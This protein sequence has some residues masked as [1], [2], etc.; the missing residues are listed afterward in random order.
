MILS[1]G[2]KIHLIVR[3]QFENDLRRHFVGEVKAAT[4]I[5]ARIESY[6]FVFDP[7]KNE[8]AKRPEMRTKIVSLV[9]NGNV[10]TIIPPHV[11]LSAL[12]Y[13]MSAA[14]R[15]VVSNG[16]DFSLDINEFGTNR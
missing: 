11:D 1:P 13:E 15:L 9:D 4:E 3:R 6:M 5:V 2:E 8:Y 7:V 14:K 10:I 16:K 12:R